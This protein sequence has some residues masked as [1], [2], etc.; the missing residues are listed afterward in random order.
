MRYAL[1]TGGSRGI[2]KAIAQELAKAGLPVIINY[3]SNTE[4]AQVTLNEIIEQ[5][6]Q[7]ELLSFD[8]SSPEAIEQA[9]ADWEAK[10]PDDYI[11]VVVNN[12]GIR[13]DNLMIFMQKDRK[14]TRLNSSH[15]NISYAVFCLKKK[16]VR[17]RTGLCL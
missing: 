15:A 10:H 2:G 3:R 11:A 4:A 17:G 14:S 12:A 6:G 7:A 5:G 16:T 9:L 13:R 8:V 1:V